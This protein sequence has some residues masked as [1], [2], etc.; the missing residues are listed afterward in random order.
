[1]LLDLYESYD[2]NDFKEGLVAGFSSEIV[3]DNSI[4][5]FPKLAEPLLNPAV[6]RRKEFTQL[7][8]LSPATA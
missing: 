4:Q 5:L 1:M 7:F 2:L 8:V 3:N 6:L